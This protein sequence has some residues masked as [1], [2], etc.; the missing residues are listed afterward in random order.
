MPQIVKWV[1]VDLAIRVIVSCIRVR[2][3]FTRHEFGKHEHDTNF[4]SCLRYQTRTRHGPNTN[5][6]RTRHEFQFVSCFQT[7]TRHET[8]KQETNEQN[9]VI[10]NPDRSWSFSVENLMKSTVKIAV[11]LLRDMN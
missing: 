7:R 5:T 3:E 2:H 11:K 6:T 9:S 10:G 8:K 1:G 4:N